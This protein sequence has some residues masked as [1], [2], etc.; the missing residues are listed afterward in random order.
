MRTEPQI[1]L[2]HVLLMRR[3][4]RLA[5]KYRGKLFVKLLNIARQVNSHF[6]HGPMDLS[7]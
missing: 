1:Q 7:G 6:I 4:G 2:F 3:D 5:Q